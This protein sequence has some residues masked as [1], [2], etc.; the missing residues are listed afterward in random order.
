MFTATGSTTPFVE[1][2]NFVDFLTGKQELDVDIGCLSRS[3]CRPPE[4]PFAKLLFY[5][6]YNLF[7]INIR[8]ILYLNVSIVRGPRRGN[9]LGGA[10]G[11]R[12]DE[13]HRCVFPDPPPHHRPRGGVHVIPDVSLCHHDISGGSD[14][15]HPDGV[16]AAGLGPPPRS[17]R[18]FASSCCR[19]IYGGGVAYVPFLGLWIAYSGYQ[20]ARSNDPI[21]RWAGFI[22]LV[23]TL[24]AF[25]IAGA[26]MIGYQRP[27]FDM[28]EDM[29]SAQVGPIDYLK[30]SLK[31]LAMS[32]G[33]WA[34]R[35]AYPLSAILVVALILV[36]A[37]C[38]AVSLL[39]VVK[40]DRR[41]TAV[42]LSL[43]LIAYLLTALA[44]GVARASWSRDSLLSPRYAAVSVPLMFGVY[45][46]WECCGPPRWISLGRMI[47]FT[48]AASNLALN[49]NMAADYTWRKELTDQFEREVRDGVS[50]PRLVSKYARPTHHDHDRLE[51]YLK[52]L[53]DAKVGNYR[54]LPPD[55]KFRE[56]SLRLTP[57]AVHNVTWDGKAGRAT[58]ERPF[59]VF[60]L[61]RPE[62][63]CGLRIKYSNTN[64][65]KL[66][67]FFQVFMHRPGRPPGSDVV[68]YRHLSLPTGKEVD[69]PVW[70]YKTIDRIRV[71]PDKRPMRLHDPRRSSSCSP[72]PTPRPG[73]RTTKAPLK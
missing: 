44:V 70:I 32:L 68:R 29:I 28:R 47:L 22:C 62:F 42:G 65:E 64:E 21:E 25:L 3:G 8:P 54:Y 56:V 49:N 26:S 45:F 40:P 17:R 39:C 48:I 50:I 16:G 52:N 36:C 2:W 37:A 67:P 38:L 6:D 58:G 27:R 66:N 13:L 12:S 11:A 43:Y 73:S 7:G 35:P 53:R 14:P 30:G 9:D 1:D 19:L 57:T 63:V 33:P 10:S 71:H 5:L 46:V 55:P 4:C 18:V 41:A 69:V 72:N 15:D 31:F 20:M 24:S 23:S 34:R 59:L 61:E 51:S 60:D